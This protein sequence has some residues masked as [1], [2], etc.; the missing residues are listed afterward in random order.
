M[1]SKLSRIVK[2]LQAQRESIY[3]GQFATQSNPLDFDAVGQRDL[4]EYERGKRDRLVF[5][6]LQKIQIIQ[7]RSN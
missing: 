6:A 7:M 3:D 2:D 4:A 5:L 1:K